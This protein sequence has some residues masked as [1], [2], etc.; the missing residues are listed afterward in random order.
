MKDK[1]LLFIPGYNCEKQIVRVLGQLDD[2]IMQ[3]IDKII[4]VNNRS[5]DSTEFVVTE[6]IENHLNLPISLLRNDENYG[7]GGSHKV[8]FNYAMDHGYEHVIVLHGDDQ[9]DIHDLK[10]VLKKK[11]YLKYDCCLGARFMNGSK[12]QGYSKF[13]T[14]GNLV[15]DMLFSIVVKKRIFDLGSGLNMYQVSMLKDKFYEKFPDNL[16]FNYCMIMASDFYKHK[17]A[18]FPISWREDDQVSNV[19]MMN[20]AV[21]VLKMLGSYWLKKEE[22]I[23]SEMRDKQV[24]QY[25]AQV[26]AEGRIVDINE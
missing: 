14:F 3:Y 6:F 9:G 5:T 12:L 1:I 22:F 18:F 20:Q 24:E 7:L 17:I 2:E 19:K 25:T 10:V 15:Y 8:A 16:M 11:I 21:K 26:I 4:V 13:R 23:K